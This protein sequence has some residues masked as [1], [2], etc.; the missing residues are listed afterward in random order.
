VELR[1]Q[2]RPISVLQCKLQCV[3][4]R[5]LQCGE[6]WGSVFAPGVAGEAKFCEKARQKRP[7][8]VKRGQY[9]KRIY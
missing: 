8:F 2:K 9:T 1:C 3:L 6:V 7:I 5:K 4:Q